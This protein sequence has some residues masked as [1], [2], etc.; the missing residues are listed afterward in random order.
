MHVLDQPIQVNGMTFESVAVQSFMGFQRQ[1][2]HAEGIGIILEIRG[3]QNADPVFPDDQSQRGVI[4]YRVD[5]VQDGS[6][7]GTP[8]D[9]APLINQ[10]FVE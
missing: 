4:F 8:Y 5:G 7:S 2:F 6:L 10:W 1:S 3:S 9:G